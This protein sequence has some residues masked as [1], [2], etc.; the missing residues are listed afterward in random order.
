MIIQMSP[1]INGLTVHA[2]AAAQR[3]L[4]AAAGADGL[5]R[6]VGDGRDRLV[7]IGVVGR[8]HQV[9]FLLHGRL[10]PRRRPFCHSLYL[11]IGWAVVEQMIRDK[12][13]ARLLE[14]GCKQ[15]V[16]WRRR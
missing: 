9:W 13:W 6:S 10:L 4:A 2:P 15:A 14:L 8:F 3:D 11:P 12:L 7:G 16:S 1:E 5:Y